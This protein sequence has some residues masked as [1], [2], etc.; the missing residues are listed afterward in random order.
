MRT[1]NTESILGYP[2]NAES[3]DTCVQQVRSWLEKR[4][5]P[6]FFACA[7]PHSLVVAAHDPLYRNA[8]LS[9]DLLTPDGAGIVL[10]SRILGGSIRSRITGTDVFV[11]V[12]KLLNDSRGSAFFL[13]STERNLAA[14][15]VKMSNEYPNIQIAGTY[16]PPFKDIFSLRDNDA[17]I[18]AI[19]E[20]HP[21]VLW[22]GM[23]APKQEKWVHENLA[24]LDVG[25]VGAIGAVFDFYTGNVKRSHPVF[26]RI[27]LEWLPRLI[28]E[29]KRLWR[30][31]FVSTPIFL[32]WIA[33]AKF[34][35][36]LN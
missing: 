3:C 9:A 17:M 28:K 15:R 5:Q 35:Q 26:Q 12:N 22:V 16:S 2:I 11:S 23:T 6:H 31:N 29:P 4:E 34:E 20:V 18:Q 19:N 14:I 33:K 21:D 1:F 7:N 24:R 30:R 25:F 10:A 13:G 8:L 27:G 32:W 36:I